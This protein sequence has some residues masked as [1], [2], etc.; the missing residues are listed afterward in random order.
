[1]EK[2]KGK[3]QKEKGKREEAGSLF[4]P[5]AFCLSTFA[6]CLSSSSR[7]DW[8]THRANP[9]RTGCI[10]G[11]PGPKAGKVLW[12]FKAQEHFIASPVAEGRTLLVSSLGGLNTGL[13][14]AL[15]LDP[16]PPERVLWTKRAPF[17]KLPMVCSP[18]VAD[19]LIVF[20]DGMH[21]TD[22]AILYA[23]KADTARPFWQL[24][25]PGKLVHLECPPAIDKGRVFIGGGEAGVIA[26]DIKRATLEGK[27]LDFPA[28]QEIIAQR[29]KEL[30][31]RYEEE[32][33]KDP[34]FAIPP[35]EDALPK[36]APKVLWR[37]GEAKW[38]VDA[39]IAVAADR[40]IIA[41][42]YIEEDKV[43][44]RAIICVNAADGAPV[45]EQPLKVNPWAGPTVA[46]GNTVIVGCS[47]IRYDIKLIPKAQGEVVALD[48]GNGQV[49]WRRDT[50]GGV[51]ASI[52]VKDNL[53]VFTCTDG[54]VRAWDVQSGQQRWEFLAPNPFFA[55]PALAGGTAYVA[56][57]KAV[58]YALNLADGKV[59]WT[60]DVAA[61][62]AVQAPG[63]VY[64]SPIV[65]GGD[66]YLATCNIEA[67]GATQQPCAVVC[68]SDRSAAAAA[69]PT[70]T[71]NKARR[72]IEIPC[73]I[74][75]RKLPNLQEI[76]PLE[77]V[78]TYPA[79]QGQKAHETVV[80]FDVRP[81][82][83]AKALEAFGLKPGSPARGDEEPP[84]GPE[85][86]VALALPGVVEGKPRLLPMERTMVDRRTG[87]A[88]PPLK[89]HFT[90][91]VMRQPDP[92]KPLKTYG[93][94]L[95]GTL[96]TLFPVTD[97]TVLQTNLTMKDSTLLRM[98]VNKNVLPDEGTPVTLIIEAQ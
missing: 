32:R 37:Q 69:A 86:K 6:F 5:F 83:V 16:N 72:R 4:L 52:A 88:L 79:P 3:R 71:V 14:R 89:W 15:S 41:S 29:W 61:D 58:L 59:Q 48:L 82:D 7:A 49:R 62:P 56:D 74:A 77:V 42:A 2:A 17:L 45:W 47:S 92:D 51:L 66:L 57:L 27:E 85:V 21:Q 38:H 80:V 44:K 97:E 54:R 68:I 63:A 60:L 76:Y 73:R 31:A 46:A 1:M 24:P 65:Y 28:I 8:L 9:E 50:P 40:V 87:K 30:S 13:F 34:Q 19:G 91:S 43:G 12:V 90:G 35:S 22:G 33:K 95:G 67:T 78:A 11:L 98:E 81:S 18:A 64:G 53:A 55:G 25:L 10:D 26:A 94:D 20:G 75:P 93:A 70:F 36:P 39:P 84:R 23:L 96:I